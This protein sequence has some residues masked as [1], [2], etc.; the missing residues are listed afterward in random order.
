MPML[1]M[2]SEEALNKIHDMLGSMMNM[3]AQEDKNRAEGKSDDNVSKLIKGLIDNAD[4][5]AAAAAGQQLE[6]LA[7][8][9]QEISKIDKT[10]L[11][12]IAA[13]INTINGVLNKLNVPDNVAENISKLINAIKKLGDIDADVSKNLSGFLNQLNINNSA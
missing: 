8:G 6:S 4:N 12:E 9:M 5:K 2:S 3:Y 11:N 10:E 13:S 1:Q 7:K